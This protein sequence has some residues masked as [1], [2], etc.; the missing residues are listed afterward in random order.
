MYGDIIFALDASIKD[1][2]NHSAEKCCG[3]KIQ[4]I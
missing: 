1:A 4:Y 2:L 3:I